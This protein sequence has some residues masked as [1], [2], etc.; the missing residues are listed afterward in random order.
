MILLLLV[1]LTKVIIIGLST[2]LGG[3]LRLARRI[4]PC[5]IYANKIS[6]LHDSKNKCD[7]GKRMPRQAQHDNKNV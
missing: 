6:E 2:S 7:L 1:A 5:N 3:V 4:E